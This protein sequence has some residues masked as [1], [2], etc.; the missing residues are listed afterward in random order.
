[1]SYS[2]L[3]YFQIISIFGVSILVIYY[4]KK[5]FLSLLA[6]NKNEFLRLHSNTQQWS[7]LS[8]FFASLFYLIVFTITTIYIQK[9]KSN[10]VKDFINRKVYAYGYKINEIREGKD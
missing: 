5:G 3:K 10:T 9:A 4:I 2:L 8:L 1:M 7:A 6:F